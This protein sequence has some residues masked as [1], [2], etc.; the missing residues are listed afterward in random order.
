M[1]DLRPTTFSNQ[2]LQEIAT[3]LSLRFRVETRDDVRE[4]TAKL[5]AKVNRLRARS[6]AHGVWII[7]E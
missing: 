3:A 2:E 7:T 5:H 1:A 4:T 6:P